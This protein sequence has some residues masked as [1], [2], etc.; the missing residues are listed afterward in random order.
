MKNKED[1][2]KMIQMY[3]ELPKR[4]WMVKNFKEILSASNFPRG[5]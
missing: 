2:L 4:F 1:K 5:D 3:L